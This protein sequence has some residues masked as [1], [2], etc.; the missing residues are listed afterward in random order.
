MDYL[1]VVFF[2]FNTAIWYG[3]AGELMDAIAR[4]FGNF[5]NF[6]SQMSAKTVAVQGSGWGWLVRNVCVCVCVCM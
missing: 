1:I 4:D 3:P 5:D 6:K 2:C